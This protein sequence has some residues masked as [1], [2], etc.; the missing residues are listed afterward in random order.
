MRL[1]RPSAA[2]VPS[3]LHE[4]RSGWEWD[5]FFFS[6]GDPMLNRAKVSTTS[7][8]SGFREDERP[9]RLPSRFRFMWEN[10]YLGSINLRWEP[11]THELP[12]PVLGHIGYGVI[13]RARGRG[14]ASDALRQML[15][16]AW[17][18][19]L[20]YVD[21]VTDPE[22]I[23]SQRVIANAGGTFVEEFENKRPTASC[24]EI[25]LRWRITRV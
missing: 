19:G 11:G 3:Y 16:L 20:Q 23:A 15:P 25:V 1:V 17:E 7:L 22:N 21:V 12:F 2:Y 24:G 10:G 13:P 6:D 9:G 4:V 8:L 18:Q 14:V 5:E